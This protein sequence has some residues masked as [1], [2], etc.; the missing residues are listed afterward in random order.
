MAIVI[1]SSDLMSGRRYERDNFKFN[2]F[3]AFKK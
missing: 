2:N 3:T 1:A